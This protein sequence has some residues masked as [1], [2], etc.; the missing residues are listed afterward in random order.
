M[1]K[2]RIAPVVLACA[3]A[4]LTACGGEDPDTE[5]GPAATS[6]SPPAA[7][8]PAAPATPAATASS[9]AAANTAGDKRLCE[10]VKKS[11]DEMKARLVSAVQAG[12]DPDVEVTKILAEM[13]RTATALAA[14]G[15][16]GAAGTALKKFGAENTKAA[17]AADPS[18]AADSAAM[19]KA[20]ADLNAACKAAGVTT[21]F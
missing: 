15:G 5:A 19:E 10:S 4:T 1:K 12:G 3:L 9:P 13:G 16:G 14:T 21:S 2:T 17:K 7:T 8:T 6:A 11:G 18:T 20:G